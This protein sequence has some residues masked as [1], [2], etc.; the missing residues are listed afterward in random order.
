MYHPGKANVVADALSRKAESMGSLAFISAEERPVALDIQSLANRLVRQ[1]I[2]EPSR[3]LACVVARSSLFEKI[4]ARQYDDPYLMIL[5]ETVLRGGT[6][7]VTIGADGVLRLQ[8]RLCVPNVDGLWK[9]I[10]EEA[11]SSRYSIHPATTKMYRDLSLSGVHPVFHLSMHRK[12]H[13]DM[14]HV[15][16]F[17][18]V[19]LD[20]SLGY[21]EE[22]LAIVDK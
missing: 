1:D 16:D 19:Q 11:H 18:I 17:S 15:L 21:E 22:L 12:Y 9:Q 13:A 4:K 5:R 7:E 3:V 2:S 8:D 20:N 10:L 6:K 14:S